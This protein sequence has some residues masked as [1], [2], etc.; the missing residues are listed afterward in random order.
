MFGPSRSA[1]TIVFAV[2][3][4]LLLPAQIARGQEPPAL[5]PFGTRA[6]RQE[7]RRDDAVPG[8]L[9]TSD[10]KVHP[11]QL[12]LTRDARLKIFDEERKRHREIP[13]KA[14]ERI[15]CT[16]QKE[17]VE[18]EWRFKENASDEKY[19]T[20]RTYP[21]REYTHKI[22]L[23]NRQTVQGTLSGIV[24]VQA[25]SAEQPV[26]YLL[27]KRDKGEP[28]TDLKSLVY[29]RSIRLGGKALEEGKQKASDQSG[30]AGKRKA[31]GPGKPGA[32]ASGNKAS[33]G[34]SS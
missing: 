18:K 27:H 31:E 34:G 9:E 1:G 12:S 20:G 19:F 13:L 8:Y 17:W 21:A 24:Y 4:A 32:K 3:I 33:R 29:V 11:G 10:G 23:Q 25:E 2:S 28:G 7:D 15:D 26:R 14:I 22:T 5:N 30:T 16:V 6:E